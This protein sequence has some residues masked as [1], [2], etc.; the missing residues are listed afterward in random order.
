MFWGQARFRHNRAH[1]NIYLQYKATGTTK[2]V[3]FGN[4]I[5]TQLR[6]Y[7]YASVTSPGPGQVRAVWLG[8]QAPYA[9]TTRPVTTQ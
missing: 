4:P 9:A 6:N 5:Q 1:D 8:G 7:F 3:N 2:W